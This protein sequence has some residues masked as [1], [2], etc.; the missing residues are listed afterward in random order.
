VFLQIAARTKAFPT[1]ASGDKKAMA[2]EVDRATALN[3]E[4]RFFA[5][6]SNEQRLKHKS[7]ERNVELLLMADSV[8]TLKV[9]PSWLNKS[10]PPQKKQNQL[11]ITNVIWCLSIHQHI[12]KPSM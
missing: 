11:L 1:T 5:T 2:I 4:L 8:S 3:A 6:R 7:G 10:G 12:I 9:F